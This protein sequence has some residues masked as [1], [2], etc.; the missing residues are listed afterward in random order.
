M[1]MGLRTRG[2]VA[3]WDLALESLIARP[4]MLMVNDLKVSNLK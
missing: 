3:N 1:V 2:L 4:L